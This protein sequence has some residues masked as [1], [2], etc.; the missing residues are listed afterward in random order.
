M[1]IGYSREGARG[2]EKKAAHRGARGESRTPKGEDCVR[3]G[4]LPG[5][6]D[7]DDFLQT[8]CSSLPSPLITFRRRE[9]GGE[10]PQQSPE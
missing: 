7:V 10:R 4:S 6:D 5:E 2:G 9:D 8:A 1:K 3:N